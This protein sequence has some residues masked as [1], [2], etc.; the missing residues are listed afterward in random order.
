MAGS[1]WSN[2]KH[3]RL[4]RHMEADPTYRHTADFSIT[5]KRLSLNRKELAVERLCFP[6]G[7]ER[8]AVTAI[9]EGISRVLQPGLF[10]P[11]RVT[12]SRLEL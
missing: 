7:Y 2:S 5:S 6:G 11:R 12:V 1:H 10:L 8:G 4:N 9:S 3:C